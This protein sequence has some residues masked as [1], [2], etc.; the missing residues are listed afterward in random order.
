MREMD[1]IAY[2]DMLL[3]TTNYAIGE[4]RVRVVEATAA[5]FEALLSKKEAVEG[6]PLSCSSSAH[7]KR[8]C[9]QAVVII[10]S[11]FVSNPI[12]LSIRNAIQQVRRRHSTSC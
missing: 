7:S 9:M 11:I 6:T 4:S 12:Y 3:T 10:Q 8:K 2:S 5:R 1:L